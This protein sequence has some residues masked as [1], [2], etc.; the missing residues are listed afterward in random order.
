VTEGTVLVASGNVLAHDSDIEGDL[1]RV[2]AVNGQAARVGTTLVG[3][4]GALLPGADGQY[5]YALASNLPSWGDPS[6][7]LAPPRHAGKRPAFPSKKAPSKMCYHTRRQSA[8]VSGR[9]SE[10]HLGFL[11]RHSKKS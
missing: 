1:L 2:S 3:T 11:L 10:S 4:Y 9:R 5:T 8:E 6:L 7:P